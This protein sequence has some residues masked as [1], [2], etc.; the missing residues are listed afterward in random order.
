[1]T[2]TQIDP[3]TGEELPPFGVEGGTAEDTNELYKKIRGPGV[4]EN[5]L[6]LVKA[7]APINTQA[8]TYTKMQ[9][10]SGKIKMLINERTHLYKRLTNKQIK[11]R[12]L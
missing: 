1:M 9:L 7:N 3:Q 5:A 10:G 6:Y 12:E 2:K 11:N 4:E 8:Y